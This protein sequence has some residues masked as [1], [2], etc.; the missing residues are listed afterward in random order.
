MFYYDCKEGELPHSRFNLNKVL[1]EFPCIQ[2]PQ[3]ATAEPSPTPKPSF[4]ARR[5]VLENSTFIESPE[6]NAYVRPRESESVFECLTCRLSTLTKVNV[7][8][9]GYKL[10]L[11]NQ[12]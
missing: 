5:C 2:I 6:M 10:V 8:F 7:T 9:N 1:W 3:D 12:S 4:D 11:K